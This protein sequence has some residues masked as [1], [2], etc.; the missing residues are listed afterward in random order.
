MPRQ[1]Y[2]LFVGDAQWRL[3]KTGPAQA[4]GEAAAVV[5]GADATARAAAV[6]GLLE[7]AGAA[8]A[9][10]TLALPSAWCLASPISTE[11]LDRSSRRTAVGFRLEESLPV[12][13]ED[14]AYD[15][16]SN[17][18]SA[19]LGVCC[20]L[21]RLR[22][23]VEALEAQGLKVRRIGATAL[24]AAAFAVSRGGADAVL[25][26]G[27]DGCDL[28]EMEGGRPAAWWW[29]ADDGA[30]L[31]ERLS[32]WAGR[33][34]TRRLAAVGAPASLLAGL[35]QVD[36]L[37]I[38]EAGAWAQ[39]AASQQAQADGKPGWIDL[40]CG[41][42]AAA[43]RSAEHRRPL[44]ALAATLAAALV[45]VT[46]AT[47]W[48]GWQYELSRQHSER[49]QV[50]EFRKAMPGQPPPRSII[51]RLSSEQRRLAALSG[52]GADDSNAARPVSALVRLRDLL[53]NLPTGMPCTIIDLSI[54]GELI[55]VEGQ[56]RTHGDADAMAA[57]LRGS[58][59][60]DVEPPKTQAL[61]DGGV[62]FVF[63]A[64]PATAASPSTPPE[65]QP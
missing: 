38:R 29:L 56:A 33:S 1:S 25:I 9:P 15:C 27:E 7:A 35:R 28:V 42:L 12:A 31:H 26:C 19:A 36:G 43:G 52:G 5:E 54:A 23:V 51:S 37:S 2:I 18:G 55:R 4:G 39:A 57:G 40:R 3:A 63:T 13:A 34:G 44:A 11:G 30:A 10:L 53:S 47:A 46:A 6:R 48:R 62:S 61:K 60:F 14:V 22:P 41:P 24:L 8:A 49:Q 20:E 17:A 64:R 58:G 59:V 45:L 32:S 16:V 65:G 21:A 50:Q